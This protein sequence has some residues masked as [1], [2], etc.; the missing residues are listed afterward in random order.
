MSRI[1]SKKVIQ[2]NLELCQKSIKYTFQNINLLALAL[3]H[4][5]SANTRTTS[6]ER[7]EFLGDAILGMITCEEIYHLFPDADEGEL[8]KIKSAVVCQS[9]CAKFSDQLQLGQFLFSDFKFKSN[10]SLP[11]NILGDVFESI[12]G[13]IY[14][15][16]GMNTVKTFV[17]QFIKPE[18]EKAIQDNRVNNYKSILQQ[19]VQKNYGVIPRYQILDEQGPDHCPFFKVAVY[20]EDK[21]YPPAWG[22]NKKHAQTLAAHNALAVLRGDPI[23]HCYEDHPS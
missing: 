1:H 23:P 16:G 14:L 6:N 13:A 3:T 20:I 2:E 17:H 18:I 22:N 9:S 4:S 19:I 8:T 11:Q 5:S 7:L 12:I 15:D 21:M 10:E